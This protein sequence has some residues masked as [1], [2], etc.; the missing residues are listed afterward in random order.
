MFNLIAGLDCSKATGAV[1]ISARMLKVTVD[2]IVPSLTALFN[3]SIRTGVFP[4]SWKCA[5]VVPI[6]KSGDLSNPDLFQF[7]QF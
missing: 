2:S 3:L 1:N 7:Y 6:P 5:R 4:H